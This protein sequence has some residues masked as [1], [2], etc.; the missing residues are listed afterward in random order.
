MASNM[1][2]DGEWRTDTREMTDEDGEFQRTTTSFR[3]QVRDDPDARFQP[4]AGRY[5]LYV[6]RACPWAHGAAM[7]RRLLGL[8]DAI[9]IDVVDPIRENDGWEFAPEKEGC[10][11]DSILGADYLRE[12][13]VAAD[14]D[15]TGRVTVPVLWDRQTETIVNNESIEIMRFLS[16][17]FGD[18][19]NGVDLYPEGRR[20]AVDRVVDEIYDPIN[21]GVYRA[22]FADTQA[23]YEDAV[24]G[25]FDA[26]QRWNDHL[27]DQRYLVGDQLTLADLRLFA[28]LV[29]FDSVYHTHFKCNR[30]RVVDYE[31]LWGHTRDVYQTPGIAETVNLDQIKTHYYASHTSI[32]PKRLVAVGPDLDLEA[33]HD[34][35]RLPGSPP[36]AL[37]PRT[38]D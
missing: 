18:V 37:T 2:V 34:R 38:A 25:L 28:T 17:A 1:L 36:E 19:G 8:E 9:T 21:N 33:A 35:D 15:Y 3:D 23:A 27:A 11:P 13:Y 6:A 24:T 32:N 20:E 12:V 7:V 30:A 22:G 31:H 14:P 4:E 16:R 5:H 10:T 26:L 29:R